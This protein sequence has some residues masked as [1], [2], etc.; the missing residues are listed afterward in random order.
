MFVRFLIRLIR[1]KFLKIEQGFIAEIVSFDEKIMQAEIRPLLEYKTESKGAANPKTLRTAN[2]KNVPC[3]MIYAG[4]YWIRPF[5]KPGDKVKCSMSSANIFKPL[6]RDIRADTGLGRFSLSYVTVTNGV[7]PKNATPPSSWGTKAG[8]LIGKTDKSLIQ[9]NEAVIEIS[10]A[11]G[12]WTL[13]DSGIIDVNGTTDFAI[14]HTAL[15]PIVE[16][17]QNDL[18]ILK[19]AFIAWSPVSQ[20]G[21]AALKT[22][23][24]AWTA[25]LIT[26]Q[27]SASKVSTVKLP[28][29]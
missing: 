20:D 5:Y 19:A 7:R 10:N 27:M 13:N 21:G 22:A 3:E 4:D 29:G 1:D 8:L 25:D 15:T 23:T 12:K 26:E 28:T 24:A 11:A 18:N 14:G 2:I 9:I 17:M 6:D 16:E